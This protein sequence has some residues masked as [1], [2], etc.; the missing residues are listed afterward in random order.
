MVYV[1]T[2]NV[3]VNLDGVEWL[4]NYDFVQINAVTM[5]SVNRMDYVNVMTYM[6]VKTVLISNKEIMLTQ[7]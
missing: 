2:D 4:V 5:V 3:D 7:R 6:R 1:S